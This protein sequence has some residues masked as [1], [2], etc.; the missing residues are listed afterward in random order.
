MADYQAQFDAAKKARDLAV[1]AAQLVSTVDDLTQQVTNA[2]AQARKAGMANIDQVLEQA[3]SAKAQLL[4]LMDKLRR[5]QPAMNYRMYPRLAEEVG[6]T[7]GGIAGPQARPTAGQLTVLGE[8][9]GDAAARQ[10]EQDAWRS[11]EGHR[12]APG[13][14]PVGGTRRDRV[15]PPDP[16]RPISHGA[17]PH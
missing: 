3:G 7:L 9:E 8:L 6:T 11:A 13:G 15:Y 16:L 14:R 12:A 17:N 10:Q 1:R 5:P 2:E 4:T